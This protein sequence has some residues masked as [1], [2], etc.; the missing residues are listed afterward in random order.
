MISTA[1]ATATTHTATSRPAIDWACALESRCATIHLVTSPPSRVATRLA[2]SRGSPPSGI[3]PSPTPA[4]R[5]CQRDDPGG[6]E[7]EGAPCRRRGNHEQW[8]EEHRQSAEAGAEEG[9]GGEARGVEGESLQSHGVAERLQVRG[10]ECASL[11]GGRGAGLPGHREQALEGVVER[12]HGN[13]A[14]AEAPCL[15]PRLDAGA[16]GVAPTRA[17]AALAV[18]CVMS[19]ASSSSATCCS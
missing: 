16:G 13:A 2:S 10:D 14:Q 6:Q 8:N 18:S 7:C 11:D 17:T 5:N 9:K 19:P 3:Q 1:T 12:G 4:A 15:E